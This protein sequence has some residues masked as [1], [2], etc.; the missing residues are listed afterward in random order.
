MQERSESHSSG[1][2]FSSFVD[3]AKLGSFAKGLVR[4]QRSNIWHAGASRSEPW[5]SSPV[6]STLPYIK[7][8]HP[9]TSDGLGF[10]AG[11]LG[12][13]LGYCPPSVTVG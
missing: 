7:T 6:P 5:T 4:I 11:D 8:A 2:F 13:Y 9:N 1:T 12:S 10:G 3:S